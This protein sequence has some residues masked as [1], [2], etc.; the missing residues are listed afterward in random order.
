MYDEGLFPYS[1]NVSIISDQSLKN[2]YNYNYRS[3]SLETSKRLNSQVVIAQY[4]KR[5]KPRF[6]CFVKGL[7]STIILGLCSNFKESEN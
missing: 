4:L 5:Y 2:N 3:F 6:I 1:M 7:G